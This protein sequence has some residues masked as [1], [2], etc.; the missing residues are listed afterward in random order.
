[1]H[2]RQPITAETTRFAALDGRLLTGTFYLP[3]ASNGRSV[4]VNGA[5]GVPRAYYERYARFLAA[6]GFTVL[7]YDYRGIGDSRLRSRTA[8]TATLRDWGEADLPAALDHLAQRTPARRLVAVGH[9]AGGQMFGLAHNNGRAAALL[10]VCCGSGYWG[11]WT[12]PRRL[13][14]APLWLGAACA[15][16]ALL[17]VRPGRHPGLAALCSL[18]SGVAH[19]WAR[20]CRHPDYLVDSGGFPLRDHFRGYR[21]RILAYT[22]ND[23][24]IAP[25]TAVQALHRFYSSAQIEFREIDPSDGQRPI[26]HF[27]YFRD[28][29]QGLWPLGAAWL[30]EQ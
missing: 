17:P 19:E 14:M 27:G 28:D 11:H 13:M 10:S 16:G 21:G 26:G 7:T 24:W 18:P 5:L 22:V 12:W 20:W 6:A 3:A 23:D 8:D 29:N 15:F 25:P 30:C 4:L 9:G 2:E 1:M